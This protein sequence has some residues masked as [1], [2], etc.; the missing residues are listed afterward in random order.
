MPHSITSA[1]R[2]AQL[3][4]NQFRVGKFGFGLDV[5]IDL[6]PFAGD[7]IIL[8]LSSYIIVVGLHAKLP[9]KAIRLMIFNVAISYL[10]GLIPFFGE[11]AYLLFKPNLR[12]VAILEQYSPAT[13]SSL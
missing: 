12:N 1:R 10:V 13:P 7:T 5:I 9:S 8:F 3:L 2:L 4:D 6:L 11:I